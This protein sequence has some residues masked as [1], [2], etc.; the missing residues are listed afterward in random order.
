MRKRIPPCSVITG[1]L[2]VLL[3]PQHSSA[4]ETAARDFP[5]KPIRIIVPFTPGGGNDIMG[6]FIGT[7]LTDRLESEAAEAVIVTPD[8]FGNMVASVV[9]KWIKVAGAAGI[10]SH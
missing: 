1:V 6:R 10:R 4:Q 9:A 8:V 2:I 7:K 5:A 3:L